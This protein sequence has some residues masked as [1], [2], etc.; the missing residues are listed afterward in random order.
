VTEV[1]TWA[2][3][4]EIEEEASVAERRSRMTGRRSSASPR[5]HRR[6]SRELRGLLLIRPLVASLH[7]FSRRLVSGVE[8][9]GDPPD[10]HSE[11]TGKD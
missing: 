8:G 5:P 6:T 3:T 2:Y 4:Y 10:E 1:F 7:V 9:R 11:T